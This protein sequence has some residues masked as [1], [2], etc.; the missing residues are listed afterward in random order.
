M[1]VS[2]RKEFLY[3]SAMLAA[4]FISSTAFTIPA[5]APLLSFSTLGCP[6]WSFQQI[7]DF[8]SAHGFKGIELRGILKQMDI[9]QS[10]GFTDTAAITATLNRMKEKNLVFANLGSSCNLHI[11]DAVKR[12]ENLDEAKRYI[13]LAAQVHCPY[14]RVFPNLLP[15]DQDKQATMALIIEGLQE[16]GDYSKGKKVMVLMETHG[17]VVWSADLLQIMQAANHPHTGLIWDIANMWTITKEPPAEVYPLLKPYI[18]HTHIKDA[19]L[20]NGGIQYTLMGKG[21]VPIFEAISLL[22]KDAYSGFFSFEWEKRWH[23]ALAEPEVA[24]ADYAAVMKKL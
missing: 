7:I 6:D 22:R 19:R 10:P 2:S 1:P 11:T 18:H 4:A 23:P 3:T 12:Q 9:T 21:E 14:I 15:K 16:L 17:D 24:L 20:V 5:A 8:A 13:D